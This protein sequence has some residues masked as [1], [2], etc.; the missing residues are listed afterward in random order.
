MNGSQG[1]YSL[2]ITGSF[3]ELAVA[4]HTNAKRDFYFELYL[5]PKHNAG[6]VDNAVI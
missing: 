1:T 4:K 3:G 6:Y 5:D 2:F